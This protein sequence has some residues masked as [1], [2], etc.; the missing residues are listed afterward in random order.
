MGS[1]SQV[2]LLRATTTFVERYRV[3]SPEDEG[4]AEASIVQLTEDGHEQLSSY[5]IDL[6]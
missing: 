4:E 3:Y 2:D 1:R 5:P 6:V